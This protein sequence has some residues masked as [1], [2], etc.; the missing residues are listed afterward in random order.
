MGLPMF[1]GHPGLQSRKIRLPDPAHPPFQGL[2]C[3]ADEGVYLIS[4][5]AD[6]FALFPRVFSLVFDSFPFLALP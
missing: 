4:Y 3:F 6:V 5:I 1:L 2:E